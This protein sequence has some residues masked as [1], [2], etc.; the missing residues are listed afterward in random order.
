MLT[1]MVADVLVWIQTVANGVT[2]ISSMTQL[3]MIVTLMTNISNSDWLIQQARHFCIDFDQTI[4]SYADRIYGYFGDLA[5]GTLLTDNI[6]NSISSKVYLIIGIFIFFKLAMTCIRYMLNPEGFMD[7]KVGAETLVKR[8]I[9][10]SLIII[11]IPFFFKFGYRIQEAIISDRLIEKVVLPKDVYN[12]VV[13]SSHPGKDMVMVVHR[14]FFNWNE[15]ISEESASKVYNSYDKVVKY[16]DITKFNKSLIN[17]KEGDLYVIEYIPI[18]STLA[19]GYVLFMLI[20]FSMEVAFRSFKLIFLQ[21]LAP[22]AIVNYMLD[23]TKEDVLK[24]WINATVSTF[25]IIFI[26]VLTIWIA[27]MVAYFLANGIDGESL[28]NTNDALLKTLIVLGLY[29]FLK[30]LPKIISDIFGYN[31]QENEAIGGIMNTGVGII[32]GFA[33]GK[34]SMGIAKPAAIAGGVAGMSSSIGSAAGG[35]GKISNGWSDAT[36]KSQKASLIGNAT[37]VGMGGFN[38]G[39]GAITGTMGGMT[40]SAYGSLLGSSGGTINVASSSRIA[41]AEV[42]PAGGSK[43]KSDGEE[44]LSQSAKKDNRECVNNLY[45]TSENKADM[46]R[47]G[48]RIS[49]LNQ[50]SALLDA[51]GNPITHQNTYVQGMASRLAERYE[52]TG[53]DVA[54]ITARINDELKVSADKLNLDLSSLSI[55]DATQISTD[56][57]DV[58]SS[59]IELQLKDIDSKVSSAPVSSHDA[60]GLENVIKEK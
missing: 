11:M 17:E 4:V 23:P 20:K 34:V 40:S 5:S 2:L 36:T 42:V 59:K 47:D 8:I 12:K 13:S 1:M 57:L 21:F 51:S 15:A 52:G 27:I 37:S 50:N 45:N 44:K 54:D 22:F 39:I 10:G 49:L 55:E 35:I 3:I 9:V 19:V 38:Q 29:A 30:D 16:N 24:N 26:R 25:L 60:S 56:A 48:D 18:I 33:F 41:S 7:T 46:F 14:G 32:K 53:V 31:L 43:E 28:L 58:V 6:V